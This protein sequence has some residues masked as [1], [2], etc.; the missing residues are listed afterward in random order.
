MSRSTAAGLAAYHPSAASLPLLGGIPALIAQAR[1][2]EQSFV[3]QPK[4]LA[5]LPG[6]QLYFDSELQLDTDGAPE[7]TGD[8]THLSGTS[9]SY[10]DGKTPINAN[11]VPYFVLPKPTSW[12]EQFGIGLGDLAA[13]IFGARVAFAVFADRGPETNLGEGSV[14]LFRRLG[15]ERVRPN[16]SVRDVGMGPG[17]ITMVFPGSG[18]RADRQDETTLLAAIAARGPSL[19]QQLGGALPTA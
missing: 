16:G 8:A 1:R 7:L 4:I 10:R 2:I 6:G 5:V 19:F 14:E 15:Q 9:L 11:R 17:V 12:A 13:V 3:R 18:V